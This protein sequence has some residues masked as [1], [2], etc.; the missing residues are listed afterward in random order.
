MEE[1]SELNFYGKFCFSRISTYYV[2]FAVNNYKCS[3]LILV[4]IMVVQEAKAS[5]A[6]LPPSMVS[7]SMLSLKAVYQASITTGQPPKGKLTTFQVLA[8]KSLKPLLTLKTLWKKEVSLSPSFL[9]QII[10]PNSTLMQPLLL[11][12]ML[13]Q[14][15]HPLPLR[16][17]PQWLLMILI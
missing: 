8:T 3:L 5:S 10:R 6:S 17:N 12:T 1:C 16:R 14:L 4:I 9:M 13:P 7:S 15:L 11:Q 2:I